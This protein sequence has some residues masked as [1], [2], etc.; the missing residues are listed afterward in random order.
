MRELS[1]LFGW[2]S[3]K[4]CPQ[5]L[6]AACL[7]LGPGAAHADWECSVWW[8]AFTGDRVMQGTHEECGPWCWWPHSCG[9]SWVDIVGGVSQVCDDNDQT[10]RGW[11]GD[12]SSEW[13]MCDPYSYQESQSE[14]QVASVNQWWDRFPFLWGCPLPD[15]VWMNA[16]FFTVYDL[17]RCSNKQLLGTI[18]FSNFPLQVSLVHGD[19]S[20]PNSTVR[21]RLEGADQRRCCGGMPTYQT[22]QESYYDWMCSPDGGYSC[23]RTGEENSCYCSCNFGCSTCEP[24]QSC[25]C[26]GG[27][28]CNCS[29]WSCNPSETDEWG[30]GRCERSVT[31]V[32]YPSCQGGNTNNLLCSS[33][34]VVG[35]YTCVWNWE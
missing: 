6:A 17:D 28:L 18:N 35:D 11:T 34:K 5:V 22:E 12:Q 13:E 24:G 15:T 4:W 10:F 16:P 1:R 21:Y 9:E 7:V 25:Q 31:G 29:E 20:D 30:Q 32:K 33:L 19:C 2:S 8:S 27:C 23:S 3:S 14:R 26:P